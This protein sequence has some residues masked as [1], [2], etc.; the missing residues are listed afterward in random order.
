MTTISSSSSPPPLS[1]GWVCDLHLHLHMYL[2]L[3][4]ILRL[5]LDPPSGLT[6]NEVTLAVSSLVFW[7]CL[8]LARPW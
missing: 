7:L 4:L 3:Y 8:L 5:H 6:R 2:V 1:L